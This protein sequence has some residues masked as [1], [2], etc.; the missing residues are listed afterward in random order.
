MFLVWEDGARPGACAEAT[1]PLG[2][3]FASGPAPC[4]MWMLFLCP[5]SCVYPTLALSLAAAFFFP[6]FRL[7]LGSFCLSQL[8]ESLPACAACRLAQ[9]VQGTCGALNG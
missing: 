8:P 5:H 2:P 7:L 4:I 1:R 9:K 3:V 6:L